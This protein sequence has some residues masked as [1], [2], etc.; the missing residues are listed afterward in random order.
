M[1]Q[2]NNMTVP[3]GYFEK[4]YDRTMRMARDKRLRRRSIA[5]SCLAL[6]L[7]VTGLLTWNHFALQSA[8]RDYIAQQKE[9]VELD[10]FMEIN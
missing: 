2:D 9:V 10:I 7:A 5:V 1:I 8:Y 6:A 3:E 4:S